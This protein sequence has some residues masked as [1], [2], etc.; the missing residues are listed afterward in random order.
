MKF[1]QDGD[2]P[3]GPCVDERA[4]IGNQAQRRRRRLGPRGRLRR[5]GNRG[6]HVILPGRRARGRRRHPRRSSALPATSASASRATS[7]A[8]PAARPPTTSAAAPD[9]TSRVRTSA[10]SICQRFRRCSSSAAT[11]AIARTRHCS[12]SGAWRQKA[13]Q[14]I[15]DGIVSFLRGLVIGAMIPADSPIGR[16]IVSS[17][18]MRGHP[19]ASHRNRRAPGDSDA[20]TDD[21]TTDEGPEVNIRSLTRGDG[22]VIGAAVLLFIASFL[23]LYSVDGAPRQPRRAQ[24]LGRLGPVLLGVVLAGIIGAAL[25]VVSRGAAAAAA[26]SR[27]S[28]SA[29]SV[30]PSRCSPPGA[31]SATIFDRGRRRRQLRR[32]R[33]RPGCRH[34]S[35][36]RPS[37]PRSS[38][39]PPPSPP[40]WSRPSRAPCSRRAGPSAPQPYGGQPPSGYGYPGAGGS[41]RPSGGQPQPRQPGSRGSSRPRASR[42]PAAQR[43]PGAPP[44]AA[45]FSPFWFAVPVPRPLFAGGR[46]AHADRRTGPRYLVPGGRA[47]R[48]GARRPD[49]GRPSRRPAGHLAASSAADS[50]APFSS[51]PLA[52]PGGG[53][54]S[55][56]PAPAGAWPV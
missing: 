27:A 31:R 18:T 56:C 52:L 30:W 47:A 7:S 24:R 28:T 43:R 40:R 23:D 35:D 8:P 44:P 22:V 2:R 26:R 49:A 36:P 33:W 54:L 50:P 13:A 14:G 20:S 4:R 5:P 11:C 53:P 3:F 34:R 16:T 29:S 55:S 41:S 21:E 12:T 10:V 42:R 1:T 6:F 15:S 37:S 51:R 45:D 25:V 48:S 17:A 46:L 32:R 19:R 38:W 9:W 39:P